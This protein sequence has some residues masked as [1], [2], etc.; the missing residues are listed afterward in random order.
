MEALQRLHNRGSISTG[1]DIENSLK[2]E[3]DNSE[4][5]YRFP[6]QTGSDQKRMAFSI[7]LKRTELGTAQTFMLFGNGGSNSTRLDIGFDTSDRLQIRNVNSNWRLTTQVFRD[8]SAWYHLFFQ[9]NTLDTTADDRIKVWVNGNLIAIADYTTVNDPGYDATLGFNRNYKNVLGGRQELDGTSNQ[10]FAGYIAQVYGSGGTPPS[11]TD[12]GEFDE[13]TG[14]WKPIDISDISPPEPINGFFL[15]FTDASDLGNDASGNNNNWTL[16]NITAADQATDTPTNNFCTLDPNYQALNTTSNYHTVSNGAT[17][18][19][20]NQSATVWTAVA[21]NIPLFKGKWYW[22]IKKNGAAANTNM[23]V[24]VGGIDEHQYNWRALTTI[25]D[26]AK[27]MFSYNGTIYGGGSGGFSFDDGDIVSIA[28]DQDNG[29]FYLRKNGGTWT[30]SGDPSS[31]ASLTGAQTTPWG[32]S[33]VAFNVANN[34]GGLALNFGGFD[35]FTVSSGNT[36]ENGYGNF[37]YAPPSG[38]YAICTKNLEEFG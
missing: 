11:V 5:I 27:L 33:I 12:F 19:T 20:G 38:Y 18:V 15:D 31:G 21:G 23:L 29:G 22:E 8:T 7:W 26:G 6:S 13:D 35:G 32:T 28:L 16:N 30:N 34:V 3:P 10:H 17:F 36:D 24:G 2:F 1:Y 37:E 14:I 9:F 25:T 4:F